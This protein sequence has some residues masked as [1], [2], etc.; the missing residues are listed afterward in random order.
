MDVKEIIKNDL[1]KF[2]G[3]RKSTITEADYIKRY[4]NAYYAKGDKISNIISIIFIILTLATENS[5]SS[6]GSGMNQLLI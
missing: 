6:A 5:P 3:F 2:V 1:D 4:M